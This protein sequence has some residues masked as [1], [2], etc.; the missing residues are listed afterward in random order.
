MTRRAARLGATSF[1]ALLLITTALAAAVSGGQRFAQ[2]AQGLEAG[3]TPAAT[4]EISMHDPPVLALE[5]VPSYGVAP[6]TVSFILSAVDPD[7][8]GFV[9]YKWNFGDGNV[10]TLPPT[11]VSNIYTKAGT[12]VV[13]VTAVTADGRFGTAFAGV[14]V[15][16]QKPQ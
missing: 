1:L 11:L 2:Q 14:V 12:Y 5:A 3:G 6:L 13:K 7:Q 10:S 8:L 16:A 9:S 15:K 4:G